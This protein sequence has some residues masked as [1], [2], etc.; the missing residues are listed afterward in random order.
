MY[1]RKVK[2]SELE[3][4][5]ASRVLNRALEVRPEIQNQQQS[6]YGNSASSGE[7]NK[8]RYDFQRENSDPHLRNYSRPESESSL[9]QGQLSN[10]QSHSLPNSFVTGSV[11][12][13]NQESR[14]LNG[15]RSFGYSHQ[16]QSSTFRFPNVRQDRRQSEKRGRS[17]SS[18][19]AATSPPVVPA[20]TSSRFRPPPSEQP[21]QS[22]NSL[23]Q[24]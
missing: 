18:S 21:S 5:A 3:V 14:S 17:S 12:T 13:D 2:N 11:R 10:T 4:E 22:V 6:S 20:S 23:V 7:Q 8:H 15:N 9:S 1:Q 24:S 19:P 16:R